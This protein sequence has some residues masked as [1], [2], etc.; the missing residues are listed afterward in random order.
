MFMSS[1]L[2]P[3][4]LM[5]WYVLGGK[6]DV[7]SVKF[8]AYPFLIVCRHATPQLPGDHLPVFLTKICTI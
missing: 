4:Y 7:L 6:C 5:E 8:S 3:L 1:Y 2:L